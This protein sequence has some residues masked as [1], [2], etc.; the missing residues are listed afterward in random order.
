MNT[1]YEDFGVP[2]SA[3]QAQIKKAYRDFC[4]RHHPDVNGNGDSQLFTEMTEIYNILS[5][6]EL[7]KEYDKTGVKPKQK[8]SEADVIEKM[9]IERLAIITNNFIDIAHDKHDFTTFDFVVH[10]RV[11]VQENLDM[12]AGQIIEQKDLITQL[13]IVSKKAKKKKNK[14]VNIIR[15]VFNKKIEEHKATIDNLK[16]ETKVAKRV[17][18]L[19][20]EYYYQNEEVE[21]IEE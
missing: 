9:A 18:K 21:L 20:K 4:K 2:P 15:N 8:L 11:S 1:L 13:R 14:D 16:K 5:N 12:F 3:T 19:L 6:T 7:R 17:L 10:F